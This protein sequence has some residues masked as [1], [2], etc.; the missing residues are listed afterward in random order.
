MQDGTIGRFVC[1]T[2]LAALGTTP[3]AAAVDLSG[4]YVSFT[5]YACRLTSVQTGTALRTSGSCSINSLTFQISLAGTVD[6]ATGAFSGTGEIPGLCDLAC[7]GTGDGEETHS[8]C[9]SSVSACNGPISATKCGNGV[10]DPLEN[11]EAGINADRGCCLA[12]CRLEPA[13]S[14]CTTDGQDLCSGLC[15]GTGTCT[16]VSLPPGKCRRAVALRDVARC[17]ATQ[18]DTRTDAAACRRRCKPAAIR[19]L[20]YAQSECREDPSSHTYAA[21]QELRIRRGDRAP[22]TVATFDSPRVADPLG[23]C[24]AWAGVAFGGSSVLA[25]PLQRLGMSPDGSTIVYEVNDAAPFF[26]FGPLPPEENGFFMVRADGTGGRRLG[27]PSGDTSFRLAPAF[28]KPSID[29]NTLH[30]RSPDR[31]QPGRPARHLHGPGTRARWSA[32]GAD[33]GA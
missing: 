24:P 23:F 7:S 11:C 27:S 5:P 25:F 6:P 14:V 22:I 32:G 16:H 12:R 26:P 20:A 13:G 31:L 21:H 8:N 19:T 1:A 3:P 30:L 33:R 15:D 29:L 2:L 9:T 18:C 28:G 17:M 10:L 4:D